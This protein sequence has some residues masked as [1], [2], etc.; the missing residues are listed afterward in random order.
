ML[1][2]PVCRFALVAQV[3]LI[4]IDIL[5]SWLSDGDAWHQHQQKRSKTIIPSA[6]TNKNYTIDIIKSIEKSSSDPYP[7]FYCPL[8]LIGI[9][10]F[11]EWKTPFS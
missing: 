7:A 1:G 11:A 8:E 10:E 3:E 4:F 2:G 5:A 9:P 6:K